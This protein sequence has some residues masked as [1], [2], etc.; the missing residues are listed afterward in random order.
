M[1]GAD[2]AC[3]DLFFKN[4]PAMENVKEFVQF[5]EGKQRAVV[6]RAI[7]FTMFG[8]GSDASYLFAHIQFMNAN[9]GSRV[10]S[11]ACDGGL[12][13]KSKGRNIH[14]FVDTNIPPAS[15]FATTPSNCRHER[16][17]QQPSTMR[18]HKQSSRELREYVQVAV[19][20]TLMDVT[21]CCVCLHNEQLSRTKLHPADTQEYEKCWVPMN[22]FTRPLQLSYSFSPTAEAKWW[23][24]SIV[25]KSIFG[26]YI[27]VTRNQVESEL[28]VGVAWHKQFG[29]REGLSMEAYLRLTTKGEMLVQTT[30]HKNKVDEFIG[31]RIKG[32]TETCSTS[33]GERVDYLSLLQHQYHCG[34][35][36]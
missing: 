31:S 3:L 7:V 1:E 15:S 26:G 13:S 22:T 20:G 33:D 34:V 36:L 12:T 4:L 30:F 10:L 35:R 6:Q 19:A 11:V 29:M 32:P 14:A 16:Q 2:L 25:V 17:T 18:G 21:K 9:D 23:T 8:V 5:I 28:H 27:T 24:K